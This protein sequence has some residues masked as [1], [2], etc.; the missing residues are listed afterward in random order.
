MTVIDS[1]TS[2]VTESIQEL[3]HVLWPTRKQAIRLS[4]IVLIFT[5]LS[6]LAFGAVDLLLGK[7]VSLLLSLAS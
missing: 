2:Y 7:T 6:A 1:V 4:A 5:G 3:H